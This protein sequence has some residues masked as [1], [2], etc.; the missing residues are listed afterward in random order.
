MSSAPNPL[1]KFYRTA[2]TSV[3]LPSRGKYYDEGVLK[4][5][6]DGEVSIFPMTAQDEITLQNPDALLS[7]EA[8]SNHIYLYDD[9]P[10]ERGE[11]T[12]R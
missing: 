6:D 9:T 1:V 5:N 12:P 10:P 4:L 2:T 11:I 3:K 8:I 7:G